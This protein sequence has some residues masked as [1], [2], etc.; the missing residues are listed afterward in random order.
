MPVLLLHCDGLGVSQPDQNRRKVESG[1]LKARLLTLLLVG[2][3]AIG[4]VGFA[5][6]KSMVEY[7]SDLARADELGTAVYRVLASHLTPAPPVDPPNSM[8]ISVRKIGDFLDDGMLAE[9]SVP[10]PR[11]F[12][13]N[14][15]PTSVRVHTAESNLP[16][17]ILRDLSNLTYAQEFFVELS[18]A[19]VQH[20][21]DARIVTSID[22][23]LAISFQ[24]GDIWT[25]RPAILEWATVGLLL[26]ALIFSF[27]VAVILRMSSGLLAFAKDIRT[28]SP[29]DPIKKTSRTAEMQAIADAIQFVAD[30][31]A[32]RDTER[33]QLL[34]AVSHDLRTPFTRLRLN[35]EF[36]QDEEV[37]SSMLKDLEEI[38]VMIDESMRFLKREDQREELQTI[39]VNSL[40]QSVC[41]DATDIGES[42]NLRNLP[43][44]DRD[45]S[46]RGTGRI[47]VKAR[48]FAMRRALNNIVKNAVRYGGKAEVRVFESENSVEI[49]VDDPGAGI[50]EEYWDKV[51]LPF[52][53]LEKSRSKGTG[54]TGLGLATART[55]VDAMDGQ[56][57]FSFTSDNWFRVSVII[58]VAGPDE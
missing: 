55:V 48:L 39:D 12:I 25:N 51:H 26:I 20:G 19:L 14:D 33:V 18:R 35:S 21:E 28:A 44:P 23:S 17:Q 47:W 30:H 52:F 50:P 38:D 46:N 3:A 8:Q 49:T 27:L 9:T 34:A 54:G 6:H 56:I 2:F 16:D 43:D 10:L 45:E 53:R 42:V 1:S 58:P 5:I 32:E 31:N 24:S 57:S 29:N 13:G 36:V 11:N 41:D 37:R 15:W 22:Q 4:W 40:V 7:Q